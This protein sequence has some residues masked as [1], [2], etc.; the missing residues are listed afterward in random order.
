MLAK[1]ISFLRVLFTILVAQ[2]APEKAARWLVSQLPGCSEDTRS[3]VS[4]SLVKIGSPAVP[5]LL[6]AATSENHDCA[7]IVD[8]LSQTASPEHIEAIERLRGQSPET[9]KA[10]DE[11]VRWIRE[12]AL[13]D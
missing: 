4:M 2:F 12:R 8:L 13:S 11:A 1:F 9:S 7:A 5:A 3:M 6:N 10:V